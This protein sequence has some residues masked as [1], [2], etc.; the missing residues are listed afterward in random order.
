MKITVIV[1]QSMSTKG[2]GISLPHG[3]KLIKELQSGQQKE[4]YAGMNKITFAS[5]LLLI[6]CA[7]VVLLHAGNMPPFKPIHPAPDKD[8]GA[9]PEIVPVDRCV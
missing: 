7:V 8:G 3:E 2:T 6:L 4:P 9:G 5:A 1:R